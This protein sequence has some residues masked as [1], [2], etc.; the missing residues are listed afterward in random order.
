MQ[1]KEIK[2]LYYSIGDV[3]KMTDLKQYVL[4]YWE[5]E[6]KILNPEKNRAGNRRYKKEDIL[7]IRH[8]KELLY[9]KKFT[10]RGAK[11][12]LKDYYSKEN[13]NTRILKISSD[14]KLRK[15]IAKNGKKKY[16]KFFN[17]DLVSKYI[18]DRTLDI[19]SKDK[20]LWQK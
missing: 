2:K 4:R 6:F 13:T 11:Q 3:S 14:D 15:K 12:Y 16:M 18:I 8:I 5:T 17:S 19:K 20:Y 10:I 9:E 7:I 1:L